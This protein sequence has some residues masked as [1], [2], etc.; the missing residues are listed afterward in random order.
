MGYKSVI[1]D[2]GGVLVRTKNFTRRQALADRLNMTMDELDAMVFGKDDNLR[3]QLGEITY[4]EHWDNIA[5]RLGTDFVQTAK[6][7]ADFFA[8]DRVDYELIAKIAYYKQRGH[9]TGILSN[10]WDRLRWEIEEGWSIAP[11]FQTV[12]ISSEVGLMKPDP[13]IYQLL[14]EQTGF[15]PEETIF[16]DDFIENVNAAR[17]LGIH[18]I[19]FRDKRSVLD[20]VNEL[21]G[22]GRPP[23][24]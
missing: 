1:W 13:A 11:T 17:D 12:I 23:K 16:V 4:H 19:H 9:H 20:E 2:V 22:F 18:G 3:A 14:L 6:V 15:A 24:K 8:G 5:K 21:L 7:K 10:Y